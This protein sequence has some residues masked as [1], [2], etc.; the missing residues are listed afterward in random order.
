[1]PVPFAPG[2][3]VAAT[4]LTVTLAMFVSLYDPVTVCA[5]PVSDD[6]L[7]G[8]DMFT[9]GAVVSIVTFLVASVAML[10]NVSFA[11]TLK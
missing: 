9:I 8:V 1:M 3:S 6:A 10:P 5:D 2:V 7:A 4:P 11:V